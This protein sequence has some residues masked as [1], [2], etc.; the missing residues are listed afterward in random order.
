MDVADQLQKTGF[1]RAN[2]F[3]AEAE[4]RRDSTCLNVAL[5]H[6]KMEINDWKTRQGITDSFGFY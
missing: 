6:Q 5:P 4:D 1:L 2:Y 3:I